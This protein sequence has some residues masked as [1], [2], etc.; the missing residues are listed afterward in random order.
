MHPHACKTVSPFSL[1]QFFPPNFSKINGCEIHLLTP[2]LLQFLTQTNKA[3]E[4]QAYILHL[5][6]HTFFP[7]PGLV[8]Q[9]GATSARPSVESTRHL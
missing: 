6:M 2:F 3:L 9:R 1:H 5:L 7:S 8:V 4:H